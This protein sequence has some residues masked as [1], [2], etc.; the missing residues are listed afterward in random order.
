MNDPIPPDALPLK[1]EVEGGMVIAVTDCEG[2]ELSPNVYEVVD[3]DVHDED[4][5]SDRAG[6]E[7]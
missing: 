4:R 1:I 6:C 5:Y 3:H 7:A 2:G